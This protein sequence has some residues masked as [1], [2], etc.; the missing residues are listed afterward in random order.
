MTLFFI[1]KS[2]VCT[3]FGREDNM[4]LKINS[5]TNTTALGNGEPLD[6]TV[7]NATLK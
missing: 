3:S 1:I 6:V 4:V 2:T 7:A 5:V